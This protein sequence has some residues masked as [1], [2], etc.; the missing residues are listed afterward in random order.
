MKLIK[1]LAIVAL[2]FSVSAMSSIAM[3]DESKV[4]VVLQ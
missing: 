2:L 1:K 4:G 3:A